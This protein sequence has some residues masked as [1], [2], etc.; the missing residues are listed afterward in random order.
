MNGPFGGCGEL[1]R[2]VRM[3]GRKPQRPKPALAFG[4]SRV[5]GDWP[6]LCLWGCPGRSGGQSGVTEDP[7]CSG[8]GLGPHPVV[9]RSWCR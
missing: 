9:G 3:R 5:W 1:T 8:R 7:V 2:Q 4:G 6:V